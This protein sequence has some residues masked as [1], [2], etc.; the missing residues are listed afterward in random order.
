MWTVKHSS[1]WNKNN[2]CFQNA[3]QMGQIEGWKAEMSMYNYTILQN[4]KLSPLEPI[5]ANMNLI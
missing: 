4:K 5:V 2:D 3:E 1:L